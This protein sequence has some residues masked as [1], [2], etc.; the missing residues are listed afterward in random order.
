MGSFGS[1]TTIGTQ[2][3]GGQI[4]VALA[5]SADAKA[6]PLAASAAVAARAARRESP[7]LGSERVMRSSVRNGG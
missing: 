4:V 7:L 1:S 5:S 6:K 3:S 2:M